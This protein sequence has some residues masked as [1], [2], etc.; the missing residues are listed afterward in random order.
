M[1]TSVKDPN[2]D[3][4][5]S[6]RDSI[7]SGDLRNAA[8][9]LNAANRHDPSDPRVHMLGGLLAEKAGN[10]NGAFECLRRT[11]R[12]A[13]DWGPGLLELALLLA[14]QSQFS[15]AVELAQKVHDLEPN[16]LV[17]LAGAIDVARLAGHLQMSVRLLRHGL[18]RVPGDVQLTHLLANDL[19]TMKSYAEALPVWQGL[20]EAHPDQP[21]MLLG[22]ARTLIGL[23]QLTAAQADTSRLLTLDP[24]NAVFGYFH[25]LAQGETPK[26]QP[27]ALTQG[28]FN[29]AAAS[30]DQHLVKNLRYQLPKQVAE[31]LLSDRPDKAFNVLDLGC[32]TGLLGVCLGRLDGAL[33]GVDLSEKMI[34]QAARHNVYDKFHTVN[35]LDALEATPESLY[36]V[37]AALDVF[38]YAGDVTAAVPNS[39]RILV[40]GGTLVASFE[41]APEDGPDLVILPSGRYAHKRSH[42]IGLCEAAGFATVD[43][44]NTVLRLEDGQ[45][46]QGYLVW[47]TKGPAKKQRAPRAKKAPT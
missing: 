12:M 16:N 14:R 9:K 40:P 35:V 39:H 27:E 31:K 41:E 47:G 10:V 18:E 23:H 20:C 45:P 29:D 6:A 2:L 4:L 28:I 25:Q 7:A 1:A 22:R 43:V 37:I 3:L 5:Q 17:V 46:L 36:E 44:E 21:E 30:F 33:V 11:V 42:V 19:Y 15:E 34:A 38:I 26:T 8:L 32:G 13:P 24:N